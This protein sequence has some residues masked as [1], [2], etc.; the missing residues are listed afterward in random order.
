LKKDIDSIEKVQRR[1]TKLVKGLKNKSYEERLQA[2]GI[3]S[4]KKRRIRED[5]TQVFRIVRSFDKI[6]FEELFELDNGGGHVL[7]GHN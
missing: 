1:A 2:L 5:L 3:T 4:L 7:R 6:K